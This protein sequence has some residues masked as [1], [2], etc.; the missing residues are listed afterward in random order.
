MLQISKDSTFISIQNYLNSKDWLKDNEQ[1]NGI[2]KAGE[3]NMN[4]V[5]R[6]T[7]NLRSFIIKQSRP[8]VQK[9]QNIPA[10]IERIAVENTFYNAI[11]DNTINAHLP[12]IIGFDAET[13]ILVME[14]IGDCDDMTFIYAQKHISN[15]Q[16][17][18]LI[19]IS[20]QIHS[21]TP[22]SS[23]P[24]NFEMRKLNHQHIFILP[25]L[26]DNGFSLDDIQPG[27][28]ELSMAYKNN[29]L[30]TNE[31]TRMGE[32]YLSKGDT[33]LHGD[34]YP[35]SWMSK[36]EHIYIIDPEFGFVGFKEFDLGVMAAHLVIATHDISY[37]EKI[38]DYYPAKIDAHLLKKIAG[39]EI[40]RRLI[41]LAQLPINKTLEEKDALLTMA[42][43]LILL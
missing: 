7:T 43:N 6:I 23:F 35:G 19:K 28:Q 1:I 25:Y 36:N 42:K 22:P 31:I 2:S 38:E 40:M 10:P 30:L 39:I 29:N 24:D 41:G 4:V 33:L 21:T 11:Q 13:Y 20:H 3:G 32:K 5:L 15:K 26:L 9:Y 27:L 14:D 12:N 37:I 8:F 34:Y 17:K 16:F 18:T